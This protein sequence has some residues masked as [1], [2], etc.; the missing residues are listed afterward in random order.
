MQ[1]GMQLLPIANATAPRN[2][3][4]YKRE[5]VKEMKSLNDLMPG[6]KAKVSK[7]VGAGLVK[8]RIVDMGIVPGTEIEMER[9]APLGD[10]ME[11]KLRGNHLSLRKEEARGIILE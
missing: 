7:V 8:R 10:P 2:K 3:T 9:Y 5:G 4:G 11:V 1:R 6:Q